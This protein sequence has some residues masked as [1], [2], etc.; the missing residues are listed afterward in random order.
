MGMPSER[1]PSVMELADNCAP[2]A[3]DEEVLCKTNAKD[4]PSRADLLTLSEI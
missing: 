2:N 3:R 1:V 4:G